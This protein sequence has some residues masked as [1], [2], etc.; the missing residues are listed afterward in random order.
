MDSHW[1]LSHTLVVLAQS[2]SRGAL[3]PLE[4]HSEVKFWVPFLSPSSPRESV[5]VQLNDTWWSRAQPHVLSFPLEQSSLFKKN[6][7]SAVT[8]K[9]HDV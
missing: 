7:G 2:S 8:G 1:R 3:L 4:G 9:A 5:T 6:Y